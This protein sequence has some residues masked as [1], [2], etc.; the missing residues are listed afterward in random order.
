MI[1]PPDPLV[2]LPGMGCTAALWSRLDL[3]VDPIAAVLTEPSLDAEV[4]RLLDLLPDRFALGGLSLGA[5]VAMAVVRRAPERVSRLSLMSTNPYAPTEAQRVAWAGQRDVLAAESARVLQHRLLPS[6]LTPE[7][8]AGR[9]DLV[10][11]TLGMAD[12]LGSE[13]YDHQLQLQTTRVDERPGLTR[14]IV[15]TLVLA[16]RGDRLCGVDR[17]TEIA[18]L[19]PGAMLTVIED[20]GHLAPLEQPAVVSRLLRA[21]HTG[22]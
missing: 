3:G 5:I 22:D 10:A 7:V 16:A 1:G 9:P 14:V 11:L 15:P 6:L 20:A 19:I 18:R 8:V 12:D 2:L 4:T 21:W 13:T 17:H